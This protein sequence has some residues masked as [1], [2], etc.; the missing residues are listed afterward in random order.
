MKTREML[1]LVLS[2]LVLL[3]SGA[4]TAQTLTADERALIE[5][6]QRNDVETARRL[7]AAG[8]NV[9]AQDEMRDSSPCRPAP[10][11]GVPTAT[12]AQR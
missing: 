4:V 9:N 11:S 12:A 7:I 10:T 3:W 1:R 8:T 5:A 6:T 2:L